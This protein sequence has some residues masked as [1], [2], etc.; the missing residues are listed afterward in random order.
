M[1]CDAQIP[2][3]EENRA[4]GWNT[5]E[6]NVLSPSRKKSCASSAGT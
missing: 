2:Q 1:K 5:V 6:G 4:I 3:D